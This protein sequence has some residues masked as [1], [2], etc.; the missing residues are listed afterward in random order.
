MPYCAICNRPLSD[1]E[2]IKRGIGPDCWADMQARIEARRND[3]ETDY[4]PY[5]DGDNI[6]IREEDRRIKTNVRRVFVHHSPTG[7]GWGYGGS[8][9]ADFAYNILMLF[10]PA[11]FC[12][13]H[14]QDFKW[15]FVATLP[16]AGGEIE[17]AAIKQWIAERKTDLFSPAAA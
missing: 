7:Y 12:Q 17:A 11:Q 15:K 6:F 1:K 5:A 14:Y 3:D 16:N 9:P 13:A 10:E 8:G 4:F 2:S